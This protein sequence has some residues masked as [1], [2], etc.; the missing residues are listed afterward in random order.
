MWTILRLG[1]WFG[2]AT[3]TSPV[4]ARTILHRRDTAVSANEWD[5][6]LQ[7]ENG[8][9]CSDLAVIFARGTFDKG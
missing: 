9:E 4:L 2:L 5:S 1:I 7:G 8:A 3:V 6:V